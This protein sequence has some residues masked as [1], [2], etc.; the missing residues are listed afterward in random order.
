MVYKMKKDNFIILGL[1][2]ALGL[3]GFNLVNGLESEEDLIKEFYDIETA[4]SVSPHHLRTHMGPMQDFVLVD[5]RDADDYEAEHIISAVNIPANL[6]ASEM[7]EAFSALPEDKDIIT[8]CYSTACMSSRKVGKTLSDA[9][10][11]VKH[12]NIGWNEWKYDPESWN[13]PEEWADLDIQ[14]TLTSG[15]EPGEFPEDFANV[16][17]PVDGD[18]GC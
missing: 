13:Y 17:C 11:Y 14:S 12:L 18:N 3:S 6:P 4:V 7:V 10:I 1:V 15:T 8:Y 9:G 16:S 2:V 5:V